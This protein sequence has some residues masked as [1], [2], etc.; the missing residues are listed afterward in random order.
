MEHVSAKGAVSMAGRDVVHSERD[1]YIWNVDAGASAAEPSGLVTYAH[2]LDG[3]HGYMRNLRSDRLPFVEPPPD[4]SAHPEQVLARL[5]KL[6]GEGGV[7]LRGPAGAGKSRTCLEVAGLATAR[8][9]AVYYMKPGASTVGIAGI[10]HMLGAPGDKLM[11]VADYLNESSRN[12]AELRS[13]LLQMAARSGKRIAVLGST[14]PA[15]SL[16]ALHDADLLFEVIDLDHD[17]KHMERIVGQMCSSLAPT[18]TA[19]L[20][21][22]RMQRICGYRP[23]IAMLIATELE[24]RIQQ[25]ELPDRHLTSVKS[26]DLSYWLNRRF[27]DHG[28]VPEQSSDPLSM[29]RLSRTQ[30]ACAAVVAATPMRREELVDC[31][32]ATLDDR[33]EAEHVLQTLLNIGWLIP[34][35]VRLTTVHD[36]VCDQLLDRVLLDQSSHVARRADVFDVL[37]HGLRSVELLTSIAINLA[38][39]LRDLVAEQRGESLFEHCRQWIPLHHDALTVLLADGSGRKAEMAFFAMNA[40]PAWT[41]DVDGVLDPLLADWLKGF[42]GDLDIAYAADILLPGLNGALRPGPTIVDAT[43][44]WLRVNVKLQFSGVLIDSFLRRDLDANHRNAGIALADR[45][46]QENCHRRDANISAVVKHLL[47]ANDIS[48]AKRRRAITSSIHWL[49]KNLTRNQYESAV[50]MNR[51]FRK[52]SLSDRQFRAVSRSAMLWL[53][54]NRRAAE[55][56]FVLSALLEQPRLYSR[57]ERDCIAFAMDWIQEHSPDE[58]GFEFLLARLLKKELPFGTAQLAI[59]QGA[60]VLSQ[61]STAD[62]D[63]QYLLRVLLA[64]KE[65][66]AD[67][68]TTLSRFALEWLDQ[69]AETNTTWV[70]RP[71]LTAAPAED[72]DAAAEHALSWLADNVSSADA[73]FILHPLLRRHDISEHVLSRTLE[74][75]RHWLDMHGSTAEACYVREALVLRPD[76]NNEDRARH[77]EHAHRWLH[78]HHVRKDAGFLLRSVLAQQDLPPSDARA[79]AEYALKWLGRHHHLR[80]HILE[81]LLRRNDLSHDQIA[82]GIRMAFSF[83]DR[84][85]DQVAAGAIHS[86]L[87]ARTDLAAGQAR[88]AIASAGRWLALHHERL[89][90]EGLLASILR[91]PAQPDDIAEYALGWLSR[92]GTRVKAY[93]VLLALLRRH[94]NHTIAQDAKCTAAV[95]AWVEVN[96][97]AG[98][99]G[100]VLTLVLGRPDLDNNTVEYLTT[101]ADLWLR[102]NE[103]HPDAYFLQLRLASRHGGQPGQFDEP[104]TL[105]HDTM[106]D[107]VSQNLDHPRTR[108]QVAILLRWLVEPSEAQRIRLMSIAR[109][110]VERDPTGDGCGPILAS[111]LDR[112]DLLEAELV[113]FGKKTSA[114]LDVNGTALGAG[115]VISKIVSRPDI[116]ATYLPRLL[117][118]AERWLKSHGDTEEAQQLLSNILRRTDVNA[119][120]HHLADR[121]VHWTARHLKR[122][123]AQFVLNALLYRADLTD[124]QR[125][126]ALRHGITWLG[127]FASKEYA[128]H[129]LAPLLT[130]RT[131]DPASADQVLTWSIAWLDEY[132]SWASAGPVLRRVLNLRNLRARR[133]ELIDSGIQWSERHPADVRAGKIY[134]TLLGRD[135]LSE[136]QGGR[137]FEAALTWLAG[138]ETTDVGGLVL[139]AL[140]GRSDLDEGQQELTRQRHSIWSNRPEVMA[141]TE[142]IGAED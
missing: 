88:A 77:L 109:I 67:V 124:E 137:V 47:D 27:A 100:N 117:S 50:L 123:Q 55:A 133:D 130:D 116:P 57:E 8:G 111:V 14:R 34:E 125:A 79:F 122:P 132:L 72:I 85:G 108:G 69:T 40:N 141:L 22:E 2:E 106:L 41:F 127:E 110:A 92:W 43:L 95:R 70:V 26:G 62:E 140:L 74:Y 84:H 15:S 93:P 4:S 99:A 78:E 101:H 21:F 20:S 39:L 31:A 18:A 94:K 33:D 66:D 23:A 12:L 105:D 44:T 129:V 37:E 42:V 1:T 96:Y 10:K 3:L 118:A 64:R 138:R 80:V 142:E 90:A 113:W 16:K 136:R 126:N 103:N 107:G 60:R 38:R 73:R 25:G 13:R 54:R 89:E 56:S 9:W 86:A 128:R 91:K 68:R 119:Q 63:A 83:L 102:S 135:D 75:N 97:E 87:L 120:H 82:T 115:W 30:L 65:L 7:L 11:L 98:P 112:D 114:W 28:L 81:P 5:T 24:H 53:E 6:L 52:E 49:E 139:D 71:L 104:R 32:A 48:K 134:A 36:S 59:R 46:M 61:A 17:E 121:A 76:S 58:K 35:G 131:L 29:Q 19:R 45:W 51:L